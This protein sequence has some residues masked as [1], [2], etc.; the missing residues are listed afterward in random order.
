M[1]RGVDFMPSDQIANMS[2]NGLRMQVAT[3]DKTQIKTQMD[4]ASVALDLGHWVSSSGAPPLS[5]C[6]P[7]EKLL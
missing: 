7:G 2:L 5:L 1:L 4:E 6:F 3:H